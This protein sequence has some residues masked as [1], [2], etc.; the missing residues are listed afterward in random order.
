M[1]E[2]VGIQDKMMNKIGQQITITSMSVANVPCEVICEITQHKNLNSLDCY[3][4]SLKVV[5]DAAMRTI[6]LAQGTTNQPRLQFFNI[7]N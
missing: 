2:D 7:K 6:E 1:V 5:R 4:D 3:D